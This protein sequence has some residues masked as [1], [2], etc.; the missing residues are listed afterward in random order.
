[1][2]ADEASGDDFGVIE[3]EEIFWEEE[4]WE[5]TD[6]SIGHLSGSTINVKE[7]GRVSWMDGCSGNSIWGN[8]D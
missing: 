1:L 4:R 2:G 6:R 5:I 3:D 7:A 8:G